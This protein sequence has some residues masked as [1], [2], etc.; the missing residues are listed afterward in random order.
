MEII[1]TFLT[2]ESFIQQ[3]LWKIKKNH[4]MGHILRGKGGSQH[5]RGGDFWKSSYSIV[6]RNTYVCQKRLLFFK[7]KNFC[8]LREEYYEY[9]EKGLNVS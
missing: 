5:P 1:L 3:I 8:M 9:Y 7:L 4:R 6:L 2:I